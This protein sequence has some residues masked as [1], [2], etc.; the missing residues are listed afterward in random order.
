MSD[1]QCTIVEVCAVE[2]MNNVVEHAFGLE[3][4]HTFLLQAKIEDDTLSIRIEDSG[5]SIPE[6][7]LASVVGALD[8]DVADI[9][10]LPEGGM[11][12]ALIQENMDEV[13]YETQGGKNILTMRLS[14]SPDDESNKRL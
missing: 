6:G 8:Y 10:A 7:I 14:V 13:L 2:A 5:K 1:V 4:G 11:G 9:K 3:E 12:L